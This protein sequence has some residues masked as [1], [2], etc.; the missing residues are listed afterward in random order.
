MFIYAVEVRLYQLAMLV[1]AFMT[2]DHE[3]KFYFITGL[4]KLVKK[5]DDF[6]ILHISTITEKCRKIYFIAI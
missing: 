1:C 4:I 6:K 5:S 3:K 2:T